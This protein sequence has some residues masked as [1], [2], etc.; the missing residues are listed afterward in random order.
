M[1][2]KK[3]F[4]IHYVSNGKNPDDAIKALF[5]TELKK[6]LGKHHATAQNLE[7]V[8]NKYVSEDIGDE[9]KG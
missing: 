5:M 9:R 1:Q 4:S 2:L 7:E 3:S 6:V 8:V